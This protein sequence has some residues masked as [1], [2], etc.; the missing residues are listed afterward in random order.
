MKLLNTIDFPTWEIKLIVFPSS[1]SSSL[2][3]TAPLCG[4]VWCAQLSPSLRLLACRLQPSKITTAQLA[5]TT[6]HSVTGLV[7]VGHLASIQERL[8][9]FLLTMEAFKDNNAVFRVEIK[10]RDMTSREQC[11]FVCGYPGIFAQDS[12]KLHGKNS[13]LKCPGFSN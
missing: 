9:Y 3:R 2:L 7:T 5:E 10:V 12:N 8:F 11:A 4:A 1:P 13:N 6:Q